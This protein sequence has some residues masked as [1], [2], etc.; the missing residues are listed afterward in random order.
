MTRQEQ[1]EQIRNSC[2]DALNGAHDI[3]IWM[4]KALPFVNGQNERHRFTEA[5]RE[6]AA[7]GV[8]S[9]RHSNR[10]ATVRAALA[11]ATADLQPQAALPV[12]LLHSSN[13]LEQDHGILWFWHHCDYR[14]R[15]WLI[16]YAASFTVAIFSAGFAAGRSNLITRLFDVFHETS[17]MTPTSQPIQPAPITPG[18]NKNTA[19][20]TK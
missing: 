7:H 3:H 12:T 2:A 8:A 11:L 15:W 17:A 16:G 20:S 4:A 10:V 14:V 6:I 5:V 1:L 18:A 19:T 13:R 9:P